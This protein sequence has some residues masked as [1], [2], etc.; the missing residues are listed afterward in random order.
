M[1]AFTFKNQTK[2]VFRCQFHQH[3]TRG[4]F[5]RKFRAKLFR[6][7]IFW[8]CKFL[9]QD[10]A[11]KM[12]VKLTLGIEVVETVWSEVWASTRVS[13]ANV[14]VGGR[15]REEEVQVMT[16][17]MASSMTSLMAS[18]MTSPMKSKS[19]DIH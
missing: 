3:F 5:A 10:A 1:I 15:N 2:F 14:E 13:E 7:Y 8:V 9:A 18:S 17:L 6:A 4:F 19:C 11:H 16:S 12:L